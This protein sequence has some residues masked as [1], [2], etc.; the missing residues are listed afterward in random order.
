MSNLVQIKNN[1]ATTTSML[2]AQEFGKA[3]KNILRDINRLINEDDETRLNFEQSSYTADN[4]QIYPAYIL[5]KDGFVLLAMSF[6]GSKALQF[7]KAYIKAFNEMEKQLKEPRRTLTTMDLLQLNIQAIEQLTA[8]TKEL[9]FKI[10]KDQPKVE[11]YDKV[12]NAEGRVEMSMASK[13]LGIGRNKLF[14]LLRDK[15]IL[16][17]NNEPYQDYI[18]RK[19]FEILIEQYETASGDKRIYNK[20]M[21]TPKGIQEL[22]KII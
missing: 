21:V 2:V 17:Y 5:D 14:N 9:E 1:K 18:D 4:G 10:E 11:F 20:T 22:F 19:W 12:G 13:V 6:T 16:R 7:K 8:K 3:H 15:S